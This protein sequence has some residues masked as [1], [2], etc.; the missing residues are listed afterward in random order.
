MPK[1]EY[2]IAG[3]LH[4]L[5]LHVPK[6][7]KVFAPGR[8]LRKRVAYSLALVRLI[9]VPVIALAVYY[10]FAMGWIVDRIV[11]VDAQVSTLAESISIQMLNARRMELNY[12][13][14]RD[15]ADLKASHDS[16]DAMQ[17]TLA[18]CARLQP[19]EAKQIGQIQSE[20]KAYRKRL[21]AAV[22]HVNAGH[23]SAGERFSSVVKA[24]EKNLNN[25][26]ARSHRES[27]AKLLEDLRN[28]SGS[29]DSQ[30]ALALGA[31]DP[32]LQKATQ[33]LQSSSNTILQLST[34]LEVASWNRV[35]QDHEQARHLINQ[36]EWILAIVSTL[37][38]ILSV[39]VSYI[40][41]RQVVKPLMDLKE[42]VDHAAAGNYEIEF[43]V[44]GKGE[45]A[46]LALSVEN[47]IDHVRQ[48]KEEI[49]ADKEA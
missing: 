28:Q 14:L 35:R 37:V 48:K 33:E 16:L 26:L 44:Q 31:G 20:L 1:H 41:P 12:F 43:D 32:V 45:V 21:D 47:L 42:A 11:R 7:L 38:F 9:L 22:A 49:K 3:G 30:V 25:L 24:Y 46:Q 29:F 39:L 10:L 23:G 6:P 2:S 15:P 13:L 18:E 27:R 19:K 34:G 8:S 17:G 4:R 36:A 40:L 5:S